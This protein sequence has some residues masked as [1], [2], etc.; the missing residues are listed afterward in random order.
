MA[1]PASG[2]LTLSNSDPANH[3][4]H[5]DF[6]G[7]EA[8]GFMK[9]LPAGGSVAVPIMGEWAG[10][11]AKILCPIHLWMWGYALFFEHPYFAVTD[12]GNARIEGVPGGT[13][14]VTVWHEGTTSTY[15][16][17][18]KLS[19]P[20]TARAAVDVRGGDARVEFV[21]ADDGTIVPGR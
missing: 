11:V 10:H 15:D 12:G 8:L 7:D 21:I 3:A 20:Q 6:D 16:S 14:H 9:T 5:F 19:A 17:S 18:V 2:A 4:V 13:Y 1:L